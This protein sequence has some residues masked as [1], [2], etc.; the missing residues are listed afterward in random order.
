MRRTAM[1]NASTEALI[2]LVEDE[3]AGLD[4]VGRVIVARRLQAVAARILPVTRDDPLKPMDA[5][6]AKRFGATTIEFGKHAGRRHDEVPAD[7]LEWLADAS[8]E[9]WRNLTRY[10][11][12][13]RVR[14]EIERELKGGKLKSLA[15]PSEAVNKFYRAEACYWNRTLKVVRVDVRTGKDLT[16]PVRANI[17]VRS[18]KAGMTID[19]C[20]VPAQRVADDPLLRY[21]VMERFKTE[22]GLLLARY[23][24]Y[25]EFLGEWGPELADIR[26]VLDR[27]ISKSKKVG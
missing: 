21:S 12:S 22:L 7:Y 8:R 4:Q 6:E 3:L 15:D 26:A 2:E 9:T 14:S 23:E 27:M 5:A 11:K 25:A 1:A 19:Q 20:C 16:R 18:L 10:L 17:Q 24:R 13:E